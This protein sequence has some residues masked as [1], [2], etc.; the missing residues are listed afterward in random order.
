VQLAQIAATGNAAEKAL[1]A[2][3]TEAHPDAPYIELL[4]LFKVRSRRWALVARMLH[5]ACFAL[6]ASICL[7]VTTAA[8]DPLFGSTLFVCLFVCLLF[9]CLFVCLF[10]T[11]LCKTHNRWRGL[12]RTRV[13]AR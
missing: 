9:V 4:R 3:V 5:R 6:P 10:A 8:P 13:V 2:D 11:G 12:R 1:L 7:Q